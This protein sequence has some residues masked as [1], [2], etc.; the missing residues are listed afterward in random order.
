MAL[1]LMAAILSV[2]ACKTPRTAVEEPDEELTAQELIEEVKLNEFTA[3]SID[4]RARVEVGMDGQSYSFRGHIR[5]VKDSAIWVR[6]TILG[7]EVGRAMIT[8][9]TLQFIDRVNREY[10]KMPLSTV[11]QRYGIDITFKQLEQLLIGSPSFEEVTVR[12][13]KME[14]PR[15]IVMGFFGNMQ[16]IYQINDQQLVEKFNLFDGNGRMV[17][18]INSQYQSMGDSGYFAWERQIT[19]TDGVQEFY[20]NCEFL[21]LNIDDVPTL[22]F[23]VPRRYDRIE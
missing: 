10:V 6:A 17:E 16:V 1:L 22:P 12:E 5:S 20:L 15:A 11:A 9:D 23:D 2:N 19:G 7:F 18:S 4:G 21:E 3:N 8:P 14:N 13:L